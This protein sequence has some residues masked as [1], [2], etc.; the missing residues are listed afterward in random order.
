MALAGDI[1][2]DISLGD[3]G[4]PAHALLF[5]EDQA[6]YV[7]ACPADRAAA[8][9]QRARAASVAI[10]PLGTCRGRELTVAGGQAI[11]LETLRAAHEG[12]LPGF[13]SAPGG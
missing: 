7:L 12:W 9:M 13:M 11:S 1:G 6:R 3:T 5:G 4:L 10:R 8:I 2:A